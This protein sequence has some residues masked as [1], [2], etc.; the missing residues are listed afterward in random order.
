MKPLYLDIETIPSQLPGIRQEFRDAVQ[1]PGQYKKPDSIAEW[2][3]DNR[4]R[5]AE[6]AWLKTSFD[7]GSGHSIVI[8]WA[9]GDEPACSY[10]VSVWGDFAAERRMLQDFFCVL[11]DAGPGHTFIGHNIIGFDLPFLWKRAM[12]LD[13]KPPAF[14]PRNP[15]PWSESVTDTMLLWDAQQRAGGSMDRICKLLGIPGKDGMTGADVWPAV[16]DGRLDKVAA[17]CI[18]DVER[19]R[20]MHKRMTFEE[21]KLP[22][23]TAA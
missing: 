12:V 19:T 1:A 22:K 23:M 8:G 16:R 4:D 14:F 9:I 3:R 2:L 18:G 6:E 11:T 5:E 21:P 17:Y 7:G 15:K 20:A 10:Q 13:V